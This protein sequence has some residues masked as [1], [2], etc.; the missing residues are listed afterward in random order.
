MCP[1]NCKA[2]ETQSQCQECNTGYLLSEDKT[3]CSPYFPPKN[4]SSENR[5]HLIFEY[6]DKLNSS[7]VM[8][9]D[10]E[11]TDENIPTN[12][13][14]L[15][16]SLL[17]GNKSTEL[18]VLRERLIPNKNRKVVEVK[19]EQKELIEASLR[20]TSKLRTASRINK[21]SGSSQTQSQSPETGLYTKVITGVSYFKPS[22]IK[23]Y[24]Q[25]GSVL[26]ITMMSLTVLA[27][28]MSLPTSL[29]LILTS[30]TL[31]M[32]R[33]INIDYPVNVLAFL[34]PFS[35]NSFTIIPNVFPFAK[36]AKCNMP[37]V[38]FKNEIPCIGLDTTGGVVLLTLV[39][40]GC[41]GAFL[42]FGSSSK[43]DRKGIAKILI[44]RLFSSRTINL[45]FMIIQRDLLTIGIQSL[46][47]RPFTDSYVD[48]ITQSILVCACVFHFAFIAFC[49]I[50]GM[51]IFSKKKE[52]LE[53]SSSL[54]FPGLEFELEGLTDHLQLKKKSGE[55]GNEYY[56]VFI[57][58][59]IIITSVATV[60]GGNSP[61][62]AVITCAGTN[63][64]MMFYI[65]FRVPDISIRLNL[66]ELLVF[67]ISGCIYW[68][69]ADL[70]SKMET[71]SKKR[72]N[73]QS[74][75]YYSNGRLMVIGFFLACSVV[76]VNGLI[77]IYE[78]GLYMVGKAGKNGRGGEKEIGVEDMMEGVN[79]NNLDRESRR[80]SESS[81]LNLNQLN[82]LR[83]S[84]STRIPHHPKNKYFVSNSSKNEKEKEK[85]SLSVKE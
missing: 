80:E 33:F 47:S 40:L 8:V 49:Q 24:K 58:I 81:R 21:V 6:F 5:P 77:T 57:S 70:V 64:L 35:Y 28:F 19:I 23:T 14:G 83:L 50:M 3:E 22:D 39:Y 11:V 54:S 25:L 15:Q 10:R 16:V 65:M 29:S 60:I 27:L 85:S 78:A 55:E 79:T 63:L 46:L 4:I 84:R 9:F 82:S 13:E 32:L 37:E 56:L 42:I 51:A 2:C 1:T 48:S 30:Q 76:V 71:V 31:S 69:I 44:E 34:K 12:L 67:F 36:V 17:D 43:S 53:R 26:S 66:V 75:L 45:T 18:T 74:D 72:S 20:I 62:I 7:V 68:M 52:C 73:F 41:F 61:S 59:Y 38:Y